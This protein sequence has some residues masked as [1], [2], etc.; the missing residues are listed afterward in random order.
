MGRITYMPINMKQNGHSV[1]MPGKFSEGRLPTSSAVRP[2]ADRPLNG[3]LHGPKP[4][5]CRGSTLQGEELTCRTYRA[6]GMVSTEANSNAIAPCF[7]ICFFVVLSCGLAITEVSWRS[8][9]FSRM[10]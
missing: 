6:Y 1:P 10:G 3:R 5:V 7:A 4:P 2:V 8:M 9:P